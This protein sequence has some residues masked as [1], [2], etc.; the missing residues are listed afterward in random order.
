MRPDIILQNIRIGCRNHHAALLEPLFDITDNQCTIQ[1][2]HQI[3]IACAGLRQ[4]VRV[5][6]LHIEARDITQR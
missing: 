5:L 3:A 1:Y 2:I 6:V 4:C